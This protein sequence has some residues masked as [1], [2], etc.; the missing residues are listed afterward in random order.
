MVFTIIMIILIVIRGKFILPWFCDT[1]EPIVIVLR[2]S[3]YITNSVTAFDVSTVP[4][5]ITQS[6]YHTLP[7]GILL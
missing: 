2:I 7:S 3:N 5:K 6:K 1:D 4:E